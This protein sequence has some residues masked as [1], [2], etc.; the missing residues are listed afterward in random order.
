[1]FVMLML[2]INEAG[3]VALTIPFIFIVFH[4]VLRTLWFENF[5]LSDAMM[6]RCVPTPKCMYLSM[7]FSVRGLTETS[8]IFS[9]FQGAAKA[10]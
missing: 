8:K 1:M 2:A 4:R 7:F 5:L 6:F 3:I 9:W 10:V